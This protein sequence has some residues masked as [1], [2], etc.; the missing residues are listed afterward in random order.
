MDIEAIQTELARSHTR[1]GNPLIWLPSTGSTMDDVRTQAKAG[2]AEGLVI[3]ADEQTKGRGRLGRSWVAPAGV[4]LSLSL[5]V[6]PNPA[7]IKRLGM[8]APLAVADAVAAVTGIEVRC[9]WPND[10]LIG[11]R[12]LCG[13]LIE[14][15]FSGDRPV[16]AIVGIGLN[17]NLDVAAVPEIADFATSLRRETGRVVDRG[18]VLVATLRA[19]QVHYD[20]TDAARLR[21][22]WRAR[23]DTLG[24]HVDVTFAGR[25]ESGLAEDVTADGSLLLRRPDGSLLT[26]PAGEV[27]L[28]RA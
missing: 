17:V 10:I 28:R 9:K 13:I 18:A 22:I 4:N 26:L 3:A 25:T 8:V 15:E 19:F 5:L 23:L 2:A 20:S 1:F 14:G 11:G 7:V 16:F 27:T 21:D 24:Q 12:K 6:R